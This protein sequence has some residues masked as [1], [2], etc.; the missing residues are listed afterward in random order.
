MAG[1][2]RIVTGT[3]ENG[4]DVFVSDDELTGSLVALM[5]GAESHALWSSDQIP[6]VPADGREPRSAGY[7]PPP[8]GFRFRIF[9]HAPHSDALAADVSAHDLAQLESES[10]GLVDR[11]TS[12]GDGM[13]AN[14]SIDIVIILEGQLEYEIDDGAVRTV[15]A[16]DV[17]VQNGTRHRWRNRTAQPA[18]LLIALMGALPSANEDEH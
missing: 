18:R 9:T 10:P 16:G 4:R 11:L 12:H 5:P 2:R 14:D 17:I 1:V 8:G 7:F 3:N 15:N 13:H 6:T